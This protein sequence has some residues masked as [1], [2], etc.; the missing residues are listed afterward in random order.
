MKRRGSLFAEVLVSIMVFT[1]GL[2]A[3]GGCIIYSMKLI[4]ASKETL[5]QEQDIINAYDKYM[6]KRVM[7]HDGSPDG[8]QPSGS[9]T[10]KLS[11][12]GTE[13]SVAYDLYRYSVTDKRGSE[14][15]VI[16]RDN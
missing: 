7:D 9:G 16:Q 5:Q 3:L 11:G 8:A 10:I 2:L 4:M 13:K 12:N 1:V 15:Y 14:I 6:L